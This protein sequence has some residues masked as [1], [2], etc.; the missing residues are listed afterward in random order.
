MINTKHKEI[1]EKQG[2]SE[3]IPNKVG[4]WLYICDEIDYIPEYAA[5]TMENNSLMVHENG[6]GMTPLDIFHNG[7]INLMWKRIA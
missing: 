5:I 4:L 7:L 6:L 3:V 2:Y 1:Y